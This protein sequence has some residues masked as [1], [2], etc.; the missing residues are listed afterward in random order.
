[1]SMRLFCFEVDF[2][3][4]IGPIAAYQGLRS[5]SPLLRILHARSIYFVSLAKSGRLAD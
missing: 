2:A 1:M 3:L 4:T 5:A